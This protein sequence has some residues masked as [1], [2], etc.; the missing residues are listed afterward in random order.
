MT[1][2]SECSFLIPRTHRCCR[3]VRDHE[4]WM[5]WLYPITFVEDILIRFVC[6]R[7]VDRKRFPGETIRKWANG[8]RRGLEV[9]VMLD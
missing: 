3:L 1:P 5:Y 4:E 9:V 8:R 7:L 6:C 2:A